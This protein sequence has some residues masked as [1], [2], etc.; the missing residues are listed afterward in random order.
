MKTKSQSQPNAQPAAAEQPAPVIHIADIVLEETINREENPIV[1]T[2]ATRQ[3]RANCQTGQFTI[4]ASHLVGSKLTL[5]LV[6]ARIVE[7]PFF[8]VR[9][10]VA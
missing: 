1:F 8:G 6:A 10:E 7:G 9:H 4:G 3:Y 2:G 5:E